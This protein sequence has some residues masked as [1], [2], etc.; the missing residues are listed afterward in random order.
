MGY[1]YLCEHS[2][3][4]VGEWA[5]INGGQ[6]VSNLGTFGTWGMCSEVKPDP[7]DDDTEEF[8]PS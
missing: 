7:L 8:L 6:G 1:V 5:H 2:E 4:K 3:Y